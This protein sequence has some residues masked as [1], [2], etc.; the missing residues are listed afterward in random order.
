[1]GCVSGS[2]PP[3]NALDLDAFEAFILDKLKKGFSLTPMWLYETL[4]GWQKNIV[5]TRIPPSMKSGY[6]GL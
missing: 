2:L 6:L 5:T 4:K 1:M 3:N